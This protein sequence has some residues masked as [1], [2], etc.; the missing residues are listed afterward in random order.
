MDCTIDFFAVFERVNVCG[1]L[2]LALP[3]ALSECPNVRSIGTMLT[4]T[5]W[6]PG[7][8]MHLNQPHSQLSHCTRCAWSYH[9]ACNSLP[10]VSTLLGCY[11]MSWSC[12]LLI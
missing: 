6:L 3:A 2:G 5:P 1:T 12:S 11:L 7:W 4:Y 10:A 9:F 8:C